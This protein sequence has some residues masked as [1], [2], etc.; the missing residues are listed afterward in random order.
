MTYG[1]QVNRLALTMASIQPL[2]PASSSGVVTVATIGGKSEYPGHYPLPLSAMGPDLWAK[3]F[4]GQQVRHL[5]GDGLLDKVLTVF[6]KQHFSEPPH[7]NLSVMGGASVTYISDCAYIF[8]YPTCA[9][10]F[11]SPCINAVWLEIEGRFIPLSGPDSS[12]NSLTKA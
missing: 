12:A 3:Q 9:D 11:L 8:R 2:L 1:A 6:L 5:V 4:I 7:P 10:R